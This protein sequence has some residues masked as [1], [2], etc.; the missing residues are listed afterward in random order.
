MIAII[1]YG[2]GNLKS[3]Y[4]AFYNLDDTVKITSKEKDIYD[5]KALILPGVGAF[6]DAMDRLKTSGLVGSLKE[7]MSKGKPT[8]G[9]CLGMQLLYEKSYEDGEW[10]GLGVLQGEIVALNTSLKV[11]HMGWNRLKKWKED[12]L[13]EGIGDEEYVYFVHSYCLQPKNKEEILFCAEYGVDIPAVVRKENIVG[14]QFHPE[15]SGKTGLRL[16]KNFW[17]MIK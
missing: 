2:V 8:L 16:L 12:P 11:P 4:K 7:N 10:E 1:D 17:E 14:M 13:G 3:V 9:I 5:S 6:K 15:K